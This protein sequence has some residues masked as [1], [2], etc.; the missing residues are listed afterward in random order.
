[1]SR[2]DA[3]RG[4]TPAERELAGRLGAHLSWSRTV[5]RQARTAPA[6]EAWGARFIADVRRE[7][8]DLSDEE[9]ERMAEHRRRAEMTRIALASVRARRARSEH[10]RTAAVTGR[11]G[12]EDPDDAVT[13][14][15]AR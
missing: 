12:S 6:R 14:T 9:V 4:M 15:H 13:A 1:M 2:R 11:D 5:D 10:K 8:P 7:H 3:P